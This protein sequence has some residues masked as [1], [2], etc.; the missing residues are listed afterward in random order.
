MFPSVRSTVIFN[1]RLWVCYSCPEEAIVEL[2]RCGSAQFDPEL[3]SVFISRLR[4]LPSPLIV[5]VDPVPS[6]VA[7]PVAVRERE[8]VR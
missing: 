4:E 2:G 3:L 5:N 7:T 6:P 8:V 1:W